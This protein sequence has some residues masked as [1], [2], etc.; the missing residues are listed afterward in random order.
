MKE[1]ASGKHLTAD[2][3]ILDL[4]NHPA[5]AGFGPLLLPWDDRGYD[6]SMRLRNVGSLLPYHSH[7]DPGTVVSALNHMIDD[8][9]NGKTIFYEFYTE[10][11]K[12]EQRT[13]SNDGPVL[14]SWEARSALCGHIPG[15][16]LFLCR[17]RPRRLSLC[18][19]D[20]QAGI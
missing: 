16:R 18:R 1:Q 11:E 20:Q 13:K 4:L 12:R 3:T 15:W 14:L 6:N 8:V 10:E 2:D 5:F 7:V 19:G 17:L 9:N